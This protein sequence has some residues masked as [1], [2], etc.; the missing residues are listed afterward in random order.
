MYVCKYMYI[1]ILGSKEF[2]QDVGVFE[3]ISLLTTL[4]RSEEPQNSAKLAVCM[5]AT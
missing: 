1:D 3:L 5:F 2:L 4:E